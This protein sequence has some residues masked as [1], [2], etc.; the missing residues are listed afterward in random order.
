MI[1]RSQSPLPARKSQ[2]SLVGLSEA[3]GCYMWWLWAAAPCDPAASL[4]KGDC[5]I[6]SPVPPTPLIH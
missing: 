1:G 5:G 4:W 3:R 2:G 6:P